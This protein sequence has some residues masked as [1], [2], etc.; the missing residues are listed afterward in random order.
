[1]SKEHSGFN[2]DVKQGTREGHVACLVIPN[3]KGARLMSR[4]MLS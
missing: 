3:S 1:M 2:M 4:R